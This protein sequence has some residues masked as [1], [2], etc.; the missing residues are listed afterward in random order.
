LVGFIHGGDATD[1]KVERSSHEFT[2]SLF[3]FHALAPILAI[4]IR[5]SQLNTAVILVTEEILFLVAIKELHNYQ[6]LKKDK[7]L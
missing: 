6:P 4:E 7:L 3:Q 1:R 5:H 2:P